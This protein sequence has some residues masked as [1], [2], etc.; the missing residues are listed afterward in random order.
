MDE[1]LQIKAV[2]GGA[3][4]MILRLK[5]RLDDRGSP[6]LLDRCGAARAAGL[7]VILNLSQVSFVSSA[8]IGAFLS[9]TEDFRD[10]G[11]MLSL[12]SVTQTVLLAIALLNLDSFLSI[13]KTEQDAF[14]ARAA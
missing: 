2:E 7:H 12:V 5:G 8:G 14:G 6:L 3:D 4:T 1:D 13:H 10:R 11:L 9:L